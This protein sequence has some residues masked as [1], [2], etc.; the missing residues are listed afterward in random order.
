MKPYFNLKKWAAKAMAVLLFTGMS[1]VLSHAQNTTANQP[2]GRNSITVLFV[3]YSSGDPILPSVY[4]NYHMP[5]RFDINDIGSRFLD[6]PVPISQSSAVGGMIEDEVYEQRIPNKILR[7][8]LVNENLGYMT[9]ETLEERG[10]YS[11]TDADVIAA[12][13]AARGL[14]VLKDAGAGLLNNIYFVVVAPDDIVSSYEKNTG[15]TIYTLSGNAYLYKIDIS[16]MIESGQFWND[17]YFD[18][19]SREMMDKLM[20]YKFPVKRV[21]TASYNPWVSDI[22][23]AG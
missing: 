19:P 3:N 23:A 9:T 15:G 10:L 22:N 4:K 7:S 1:A 17:F 13:N 16:A 5:E 20:S 18:K 11:A 21:Y 2:Q 8:V 6:I 12:K 14:S